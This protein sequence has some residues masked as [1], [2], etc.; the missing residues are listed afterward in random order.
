MDGYRCQWKM[1]IE[2]SL[3]KKVK[4]LFR[5]H[6]NTRLLIRTLEMRQMELVKRIIRLEET[7]NETAH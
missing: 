2:M 7:H 1:G 6:E 5:Y 4:D 3:K